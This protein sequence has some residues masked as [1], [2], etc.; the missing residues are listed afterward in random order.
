MQ[1]ATDT[2]TLGSMTLSTT[3]NTY[4]SSPLGGTTHYQ[5]LLTQTQT[6][7]TDL[8]GSRAADDDERVH[9]RPYNNATTIAVSISDGSTKTTNNTFT[10]D[11][12]N[13]FLGRLTA[14]SVTSTAP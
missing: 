5:V 7:G 13:W 14:S 3:T 4:S 2:K 10:N 11:T 9:L 12:T 1:V 8:D 6:S